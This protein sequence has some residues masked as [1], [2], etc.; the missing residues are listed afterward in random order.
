MRSR[1][2]G[3]LTERN[4]CSG[5]TKYSSPFRTRS[6][7]KPS[8]VARPRGRPKQPHASGIR[9][10]RRLLLDLADAWADASPRNKIRVQ[11]LVAALPG[12]MAKE[13]GYEVDVLRDLWGPGQWP[14][15]IFVQPGRPET[16][17][18]NAPIIEL[19]WNLIQVQLPEIVD[20]D[21]SQSPM[22]WYR[23]EHAVSGYVELVRRR[24]KGD[25][26]LLDGPR[27]PKHREEAIKQ[28]A[29][30]KQRFGKQ[31]PASPSG[32]NRSVHFSA[33]GP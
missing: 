25:R 8:S 13:I 33:R 15:E 28:L 26:E 23:I 20:A 16:R 9:K 3:R 11:A 30:F 27:D 5:A 1:S 31:P 4:D 14:L 7:T 32:S 2:T 12:N 29:D 22:G 10:S 6:S 18:E 21:N 17:R 19:M 24:Q